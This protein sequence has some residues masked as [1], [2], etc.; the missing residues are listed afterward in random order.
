MAQIHRWKCDICG[1]EFGE[2]DAGFKTRNSLYIKI[3]T[4][5]GHPSEECGYDDTCID[6]RIEIADVIGKKIIELQS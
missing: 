2:N 5:P 4:L 3:N 1:K 6:C